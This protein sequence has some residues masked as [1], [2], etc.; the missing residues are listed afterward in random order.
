MCVYVSDVRD[1]DDDEKVAG[2]QTLC[3]CV[4]VCMCVCVRVFV[5]VCMLVMMMAMRKKSTY[6]RFS[7][8]R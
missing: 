6:K 7:D 4:C 8:L 2:K 5:C 3:V 1:N